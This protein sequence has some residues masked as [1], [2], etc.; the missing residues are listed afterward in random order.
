G[1][2]CARY[3]AKPT[4][5]HLKEVKR[6]FCY[7]RGTANTGL[8]YT[9][10][11]GF[12]LTGFSDADY[13]GCKDSFKSTFGGAQ[14]L[15]EKLCLGYTDQ[16]SKLVDSFISS[17]RWEPDPIEAD[18]LK[19]SHYQ[20]KVDVL[21]MIGIVVESSLCGDSNDHV[22]ILVDSMVHGLHFAFVSEDD[23]ETRAC[24]SLFQNKRFFLGREV[25]WSNE[26]SLENKELNAIIIA[27]FTLWRD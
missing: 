2:E 10:D 26:R 9:K 3:Q 19:G 24:K 25:P 8:W 16:H 27:W 1:R 13:A 15:G 22:Y 17:L 14:F 6:I 12:E 7:L 4:E 5:K 11:S 21:G 20:K 18:P 23:E